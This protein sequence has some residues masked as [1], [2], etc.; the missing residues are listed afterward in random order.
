MRVS[1]ALAVTVA[2]AALTL[3]ASV[4]AQAAPSAPQS[5]AS[6]PSWCIGGAQWSDRNTYGVACDVTFA[7]YAKVTCSNGSSTKTARGVVTN[8]NRWSYAY[9][10]AFGSSYRAVPGTGGAVRA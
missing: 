6:I 7:Y 9:C 5:A 3:G 4:P 2:G 10:S 1:H 8:D